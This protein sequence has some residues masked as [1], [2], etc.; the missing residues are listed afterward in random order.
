[1][2]RLHSDISLDD[3]KAQN[4]YRERIDLLQNRV[5]LLTGKDK[6][7]MTMYLSNGNTYRQ[8]AQLVGINEANIARRIHKLTRKL[9]DGEYIKCIRNRARFTKIEMDVARDYFLAGLSF[10]AI[11]DKRHDSYYN[12]RKTVLRIQRILSDK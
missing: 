5:E 4:N 1:M 10:G 8:L 12:I 9:I 3:L 11:A 6:L 7:I 2:R